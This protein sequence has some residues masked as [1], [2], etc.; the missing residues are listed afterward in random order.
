[1]KVKQL[2]SA[3]RTT[4]IEAMVHAMGDL[5][6]AAKEEMNALVS[7]ADFYARLTVDRALAEERGHG[8]DYGDQTDIEGGLYDTY[9]RVLSI[10][11]VFTDDTEQDVADLLAPDDSFEEPESCDECPAKDSCPD[12]LKAMHNADKLDT[13]STV[14]DIE[15]W[16]NSQMDV[17]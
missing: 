12:W 17:D 5:P 3:Q 7:F 16:L 13:A 6:V 14:E 1:M 11:N 4:L 2:T 10:D 15:A 9:Y 8:V